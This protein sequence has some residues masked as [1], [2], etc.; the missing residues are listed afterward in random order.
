MRAGLQKPDRMLAGLAATIVWVTG[1]LAI[2]GVA[3]LGAIAV[4]GAMGDNVL[5]LAVPVSI[6]LAVSLILGLLA[7]PLSRS[8][9]AAT[10][11]RRASGDAEL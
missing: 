9:K 8:G 3:I 10:R 7:L 1:L 5:G 2:A 4:A 6:G 11:P